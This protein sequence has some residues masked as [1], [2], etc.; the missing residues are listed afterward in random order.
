MPYD[1]DRRRP[2]VVG[3]LPPTAEVTGALLDR[4]ASTSKAFVKALA[5]AF[6]D[7]KLPY[8][9]TEYES[10]AEAAQAFGEDVGDQVERIVD[11]FVD[12]WADRIQEVDGLKNR[13]VF[14]S[15]GTE[16]V[17]DEYDDDDLH[18]YYECRF[19]S[20]IVH[21][22]KVQVTNH[23]IFK[24]IEGDFAGVDYNTIF[25]H[26]PVANA[27]A[28][29]LAKAVKSAQFSDPQFGKLA[30]LA[31]EHSYEHSKTDFKASDDKDD[32]MYIN[33]IYVKI[34]ITT[35]RATMTAEMV[36]RNVILFTTTFDLKGEVLWP[37]NRKYD[38]YM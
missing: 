29:L 35:Q 26:P 11:K 8:R 14:T 38:E 23:S 13:P 31:I 1:Y 15:N 12:R 34:A 18:V 10:P 37:G 17:W 4:S 21:K 30:G 2:F 36:G 7:L 6:V 28:D 27:L 16:H 3:I 32:D 19:A 25:A 33:P 5:E 24:E 20:P 9:P 22:A